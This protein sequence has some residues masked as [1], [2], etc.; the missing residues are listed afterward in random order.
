MKITKI[1][2]NMEF[3]DDD[4]AQEDSEDDTDLFDEESDEDNEVVLRSFQG[5]EDEIARRTA[6]FILGRL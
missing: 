3:E 1:P 6:N 2:D 4:D 5:G